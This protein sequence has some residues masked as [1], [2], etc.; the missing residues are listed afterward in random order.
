MVLTFA[1]ALGATAC[2]LLV[3][4][5][6]PA[7]QGAQCTDGVDNDG[8]G[9]FDC[10]E[11]A[12]AAQCNTCGDGRVDP[13]EECDDGN[14]VP[15]DGCDP[16]CTFSCG[17][18]RVSDRRGFDPATGHCYLSFIETRDV[19]SANEQCMTLGGYL[20]VP[21]EPVEDGIIRA[22][23]IGPAS[24]GFAD[25]EPDGFYDFRMVTGDLGAEYLNFSAGQP[26]EP[27]DG[28]ICVSYDGAAPTWA[29]NDCATPRPYVCELEPQPCGDFVRQAA[30]ECDDGNDRDDDGCTSE[31]RDVDECALGIAGCSADA[32]CFNE[33]WRTG[34]LGFQCACRGGFIGDGFT[35]TELPP[36]PSFV[37]GEP[38]PISGS[39]SN[40]TT[41]RSSGG[42]KLAMDPYGVLYAV[43]LC[44]GEVNVTAS[45][46]AG[47]TW[48]PPQ[49][50]GVQA[51]EAAIVGIAPGRAAVA[52][53][54]SNSEIQIRETRDFGVTWGFPGTVTF[55]SGGLTALSLTTDGGGVF[56]GEVSASGVLQVHRSLD[57]TLQ[58]FAPAASVLVTEGDVLFDPQ[59]PNELW[60]VGTAPG[61]QLMASTDGGRTFPQF[62]DT[63]P[64]A[65]TGSD[66]AIG[67]GLIAVTGDSDQVSVIPVSAPDTSTT[68]TKLRQAVAGER[69][70]VVDT[71]GAVIVAQTSDAGGVE[72]VRL[73]P[74]G[75][76]FDA[77]VRVDVAGNHPG[78]AVV[79]GGLV[80]VIYTAGGSVSVAIV[81]P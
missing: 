36:P 28:L 6:Q 9:L 47:L 4:F 69:T 43:M 7:E 38:V 79:Y 57:E 54:Q 78:I 61:F 59:N 33:P 70:L 35:C 29:D 52:T 27:H 12:C 42:R 23:A 41:Q 53:W 15:G 48:S 3:S 18:G 44:G 80:A 56:I 62:A 68:V 1:L 45:V 71:S 24:L 40:C 66:W 50:L 25:S 73:A 31:C 74:G 21:D 26:D 34:T 81:A 39:L 17:A 5:D 72:V 58:A 51:E 19:I 55:A 14:D 32:D 20:A 30:E 49:L 2:N 8:N 46:D 60:A 64:G 10:E 65:Q 22:A 37:E 67:V 63:P 76:I 77:S 75:T 13:L 16:G 11:A